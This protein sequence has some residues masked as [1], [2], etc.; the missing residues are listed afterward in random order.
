M[1]MPLEQD[2]LDEESYAS[3]DPS[4]VRPA[5]LAPPASS[6]AP[7]DFS[8][9]HAESD[10][11]TPVLAFD[12]RH[13]EAFEGLMYLGALS[14]TFTWA[15]HQFRIRTLT[16]SEI[17]IVGLITARYEGTVAQNRAYAA[18]VVALATESVDGEPLP[19][20]YKESMGHE[21]ADQRFEY[22]VGKWFNFTIDA[23]YSEYLVLEAKAR[24][25]MTEMGNLSG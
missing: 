25:V 16:T 2:V 14:K 13:R 8:E 18:A 21:W 12:E 9:A 7:Q 17:L 10:V 22:V 1:T 11:T 3:Y 20:P 15:G 6:D 24:E 5:P 19:F 23:V 4:T